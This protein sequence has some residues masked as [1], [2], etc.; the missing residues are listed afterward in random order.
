MIPKGEFDRK[1]ARSGLAISLRPLRNPPV[2]R[3]HGVGSTVQDINTNAL[4]AQ[5]S[6]SLIL[7][8]SPLPGPRGRDGCAWDWR[9]ARRTRCN[10]IGYQQQQQLSNC[11]NGHVKVLA[12][13]KF[14]TQSA[15]INRN[16]EQ[17]RAG[18]TLSINR[19]L[20][21]NNFLTACL[22]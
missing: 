2:G 11:R 6:V 13:I 15:L 10:L 18:Q 17:T 21:C 8:T 4:H 12:G 22:H 1:Q 7:C 19:V 9:D 14:E 16:R 3:D 5:A 20:P